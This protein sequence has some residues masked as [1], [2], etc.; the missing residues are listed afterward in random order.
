MEKWFGYL[1][2]LYPETCDWILKRK[3]HGETLRWTFLLVTFPL[4]WCGS[5]L[6]VLLAPHQVRPLLFL[7][8]LGFLYLLN[9]KFQTNSQCFLRL[10]HCVILTSDAIKK[11]VFLDFRWTLALAFKIELYSEEVNIK[12]PELVHD[13]ALTASR[14]NKR[15]KDKTEDK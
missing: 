11:W 7:P 4:L 3:I 5:S 8:G 15:E 1:G 13:Q 12:M 6:Q 10:Q 14:W 2:R 9:G